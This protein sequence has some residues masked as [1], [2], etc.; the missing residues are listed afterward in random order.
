MR[1]VE[2]CVRAWQLGVELVEVPIQSADAIKSLEAAIAAGKDRGRDVGAGSIHS[3]AQL[4]VAAELGAAFTV[5]PG[6]DQDIAAATKDMSMPHLPGVATS[7]EIGKA[8]NAGFTWMKAFPAAQLGAEW[9]RAQ[10]SPYPTASFIATGGIDID[11]AREF[12]AAGC[13]GIAVGTAFADDRSLVS[14]A[15]ILREP[16][17]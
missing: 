4:T 10:L 15:K 14:L 1:T 17:S 3:L 16:P 5:S 11:N 12:L 9:I 7:T 2:L 8:L 13:R 6:F